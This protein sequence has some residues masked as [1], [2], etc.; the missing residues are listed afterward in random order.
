MADFIMP[1]THHP[2]IVIILIIYSV[3][4]LKDLAINS[5]F[6]VSYT[7]FCMLVCK[8]WALFF[9]VP[10]PLIDQDAEND[11]TALT[12]YTMHNRISGHK[13]NFLYVNIYI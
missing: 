3:Y 2:I 10:R 11:V 12:T 1:E 5:S 7:A 9:H 8:A 13:H 6:Y 4:L